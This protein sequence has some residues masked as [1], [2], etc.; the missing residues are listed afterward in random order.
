MATRR[1]RQF[2]AAQTAV[3]VGTVLVLSLVGGVTLERFAVLSVVGFLVVVE[4]TAPV[5]VTP[6]WR[7]RLKWVIG[8]GLLLV[9]YVLVRRVLA[10]LPSGVV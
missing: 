10:V 4:L 3:M 8:L 6:A 7:S 2:I 1:R 5:A 9:A